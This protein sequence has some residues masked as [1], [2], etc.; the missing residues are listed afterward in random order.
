VTIKLVTGVTE[1]Q[2]DEEERI[3][4]LNKAW[5]TRMRLTRETAGGGG[6][7]ELTLSPRIALTIWIND[8]TP[9]RYLIERSV[10]R[11]DRQV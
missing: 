7:T 9:K 4:T 11:R 5:E 3:H 6:G 2:L 1:N 8:M 10:M